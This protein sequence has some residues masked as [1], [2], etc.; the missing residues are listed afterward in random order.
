MNM[1]KLYGL[2]LGMTWVIISFQVVWIIPL[3]Y[4]I[5][6]YPSVK[7]PLEDMLILSIMSNSLRIPMY[8]LL[9]QLIRLFLSGMLE[10]N[11]VNL[12]SMVM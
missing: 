3:S 5:S 7:A 9:L 4:S 11:Y 10:P 12:R 6:T 8:L 2:S 1:P